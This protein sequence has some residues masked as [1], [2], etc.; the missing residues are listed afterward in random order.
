MVYHHQ[1]IVDLKWSA[2]ESN[3]LGKVGN[4]FKNHTVSVFGKEDLQVS[5]AKSFKGDS[6][7]H[8]PE[9]LL[10]S[11][12][13]SCHMMSYLYCCSIHKIEILTYTDHAEALLEVKE[14]GS[15]RIVK[16][17]LHPVVRLADASQIDLA[18]ALH[19]KANQ[20]CFIANS[21]NFPVEHNASCSVS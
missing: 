6:A 13:A 3:G 16:V 8:N 17:V 10:L 9:D 5:A 12:L 1:F 14:D 21:C 19:A 7:L 4:S 20:L 2:K 11:S 18:L 15:G